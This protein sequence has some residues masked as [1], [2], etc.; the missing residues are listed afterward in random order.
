MKGTRVWLMEIGVE[1]RNSSPVGCEHPTTVDTDRVGGILGIFF[2]PPKLHRQ[3]FSKGIHDQS[4]Q[5][6]FT[7]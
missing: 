1:T 4:Y 3:V 7:T 5:L 2:P 6:I